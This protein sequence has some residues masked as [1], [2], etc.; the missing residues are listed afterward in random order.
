MR[1]YSFAQFFRSRFLFFGGIALCIFIALNFVKVFSKS[2]STRQDITR[3]KG[4]ISE[5]E[6]NQQRLHEFYVLLSSD[7][8]AEKEARLKFGLQKQGEH[9]VVIQ[10]NMIL[11]EQNE[12]SKKSLDN[13]KLSDTSFVSNSDTVQSRIVKQ[14]NPQIWWD[15]FFS[16]HE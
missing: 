15:Y 12:S 1:Q 13:S 11:E 8:F 3:L 4:E 16:I 2:Y 9:A 7:F 5:L 14:N 6:K 10:K